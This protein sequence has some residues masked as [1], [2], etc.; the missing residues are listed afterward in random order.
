MNESPCAKASQ[1]QANATRS[2]TDIPP[3]HRRLYARIRRACGHCCGKGLRVIFATHPQRSRRQPGRLVCRQSSVI[4][5]RRVRCASHSERSRATAPSNRMKRAPMTVR[6]R[7]ARSDLNRANA[8]A[9]LHVTTTPALRA[10]IDRR[11]S[12]AQM[13]ARQCQ[14]STRLADPLNSAEWMS[15]LC[16]GARSSAKS[17]KISLASPQISRTRGFASKPPEVQKCGGARQE[18]AKTH[19]ANA[20]SRRHNSHQNRLTAHKLDP[21]P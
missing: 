20:R 18:T 14:A 17:V 1:K 9:S 5:P 2:R 16:Q 7:F 19:P 4:L 12:A 13:K 21:V 3:N 11:R 6:P 8:R 10:E 15:T